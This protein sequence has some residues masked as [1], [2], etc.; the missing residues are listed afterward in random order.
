MRSGEELGVTLC[1]TIVWSG[2]KNQQNKADELIS[3]NS[4]MYA[5]VHYCKEKN[6]VLE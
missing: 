1:N 6:K 4:T 5:T 3:V 2:P